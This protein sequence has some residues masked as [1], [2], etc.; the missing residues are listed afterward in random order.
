MANSQFEKFVEQ[1]GA[2][3]K[4]NRLFNALKNNSGIGECSK[5]ASG[6]NSRSY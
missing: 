5:Y 1:I 3:V 2:E 4:P 6:N